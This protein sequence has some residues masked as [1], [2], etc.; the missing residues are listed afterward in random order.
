MNNLL[1]CDCCTEPFD[2]EGMNASILDASYNDGDPIEDKKRIPL[3][4]RNCGCTV[5]SFCVRDFLYLKKL[6]G[7]E[8]NRSKGSK[9]NKTSVNCPLCD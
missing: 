7:G 6:E 5:C 4:L 2:L 1:V 9:S 8:T 3:M